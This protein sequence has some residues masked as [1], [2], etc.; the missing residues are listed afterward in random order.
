[1]NGLGA[2]MLHGLVLPTNILFCRLVPDE[3]SRGVSIEGLH[4]AGCALTE[5]LTTED[6]L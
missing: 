3:P 5:H 4:G 6:Y 2:E 1:M